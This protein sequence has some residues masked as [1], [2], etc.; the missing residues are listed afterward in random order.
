M[1][2]LVTVWPFYPVYMCKYVYG[3]CKNSMGFV[4]VLTAMVS[5]D[6]SYNLGLCSYRSST[7]GVIS[8]L[9]FSFSFVC[10][11]N[12]KICKEY[13]EPAIESHV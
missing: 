5:L 2:R 11:R 3:E 1:L 4:Q 7:S 8:K 13:L 9:V 12:N 6:I 10:G